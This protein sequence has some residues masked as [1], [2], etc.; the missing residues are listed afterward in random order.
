LRSE[1]GSEVF[2]VFMKDYAQNNS[3]DIATP[4]KLKSEAEAHCGR[5]LT[6]LF[7]KWIYP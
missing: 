5:N 7:E 6:P 1:M 4:E 2:D 3:W